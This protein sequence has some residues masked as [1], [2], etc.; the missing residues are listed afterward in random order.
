MDDGEEYQMD[1]EAPTE[2]ERDLWVKAI[3][4]MI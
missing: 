1:L 4:M 2:V 3:T